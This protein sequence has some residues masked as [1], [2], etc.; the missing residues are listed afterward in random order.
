MLEKLHRVRTLALLRGQ[1]H[2][3]VRVA[4]N[5]GFFAKQAVWDLL[6]NKARIT[7]TK[8][9]LTS[10]ELAARLVTLK[11]F[12]SGIPGRPPEP[13]RYEFRDGDGS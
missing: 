9:Y 13:R 8:K 7:G 4:T 12:E 1:T 6:A 11:P 2:I 10:E 5:L 3:T